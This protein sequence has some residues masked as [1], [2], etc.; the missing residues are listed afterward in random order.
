MGLSGEYYVTDPVM[1]NLEGKEEPLIG[2]YYIGYALL[3]DSSNQ[4][5]G[6]K[7]WM[8]GTLKRT[9]D[10]DLVASGK[11][12]FE[13]YVKAFSNKFVEFVTGCPNGASLTIDECRESAKENDKN[14]DS[15]IVGYWDNF[16]S[17][18]FRQEEDDDKLHGL[19]TYYY[20]TNQI[21]SKGNANFG[22]LSSVCRIIPFFKENFAQIPSGLI[23]KCPEGTHLT[24]ER[25]LEAGLAHGGILR[26]GTITEGNWHNTPQGCFLNPGEDNAIHYSVNPQGVGGDGRYSLLCLNK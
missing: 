4:A 20:N 24:R 9:F 1:T 23:S 7:P 14:P 19:L 18:C 15:V 12:P 25:C 22:V 21:N 16:P 3:K 6:M 17:G 8:K 26:N 2:M 5:A 13:L 11:T 10:N